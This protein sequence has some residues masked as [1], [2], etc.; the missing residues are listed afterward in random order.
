M[1]PLEKFDL[2]MIALL[3][4]SLLVAKSVIAAARVEMPSI[5]VRYHDLDLNSPAGVASLY[6]R[7]HA[8]AVDVCRSVEGPQPANRAP[9][10]DSDTCVSHAVALAVHVVHN[11]KL[12]AYHWER[13]G[14]WKL[15]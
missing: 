3:V 9:P 14:G 4:I 12:S 6:E 7:I 15:H 5:T 13:I 1:L 2:R 11:Q 10:T 8:A